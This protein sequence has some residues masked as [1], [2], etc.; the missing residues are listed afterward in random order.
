MAQYIAE[1]PQRLFIRA[2]EIKFSPATGEPAGK[3]RRLVAQFRRGEAPGYAVELA[4]R[5]FPLARMPAAGVTVQQWL[6]FFDSV[7]EQDRHGWTD[8]EREFVE[9][10]LDTTFAYLCRRVEEPR[11]AAPWPDIEKLRPVGRRTPVLSAEKLVEV[12]SLTGIGLDA[13]AAYLRQEGWPAEVIEVVEAK[14]LEDRPAADEPV[15]LVE[16]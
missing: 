1:D 13:V 11:L 12:A 15:A 10:K 5:E 4:Q 3:K 14:A 8:E 16:A 6:S 7:A 9:R 2:E